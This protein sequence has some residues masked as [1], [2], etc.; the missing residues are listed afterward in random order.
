MSAMHRS[1]RAVSLVAAI[2]WLIALAAG[3]A[4]AASPSPSSPPAAGPPFPEPIDGQAVYD[5]A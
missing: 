3:P 2:L 1:R 5:Y 4:L